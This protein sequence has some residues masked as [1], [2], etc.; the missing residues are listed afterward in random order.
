MDYF[1][2]V[3]PLYK[4]FNI[5]SHAVHNSSTPK[6]AE[7]VLIMKLRRICEEEREKRKM[8]ET[9]VTRYKAIGAGAKAGVA[10][11]EDSLR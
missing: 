4:I 2:C 11:T 10:G 5:C 3:E 8:L 1:N 7:L 9:V 6:P